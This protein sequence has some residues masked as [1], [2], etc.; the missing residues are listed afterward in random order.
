LYGFS[1]A[2]TPRGGFGGA[3]R[4]QD[5]EADR[6]SF[7]FPLTAP[8]S[9]AGFGFAAMGNISQ[10]GY[11]FMISQ[12]RVSVGLLL[13]SSSGCYGILPM[14]GWARNISRSRL[15]GLPEDPVEADR[16]YPVGV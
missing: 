14:P 5:I 3:G 7:G 15:S 6:L 13:I 16:F 11:F 9:P 12:A 1:Y 2:F 8:N 4:F 10:S